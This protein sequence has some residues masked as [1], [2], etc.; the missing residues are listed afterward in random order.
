VIYFGLTDTLMLMVAAANLLSKASN[1]HR[2]AQLADLTGDGR[3]DLVVYSSSTKEYSLGTI[4]FN[5]ITDDPQV[6]GPLPFKT[7]SEERGGL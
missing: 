3:L 1:I 6:R 4:S 2:F 5:E 7:Q